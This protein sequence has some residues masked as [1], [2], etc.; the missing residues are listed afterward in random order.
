MGA[1]MFLGLI[2]DGLVTSRPMVNNNNTWRDPVLDPAVIQLQFDTIAYQKSGSVMTPFFIGR[3][4]F[5]NT[6]LVI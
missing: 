2:A 5:C 6:N 3:T 4:H 1:E